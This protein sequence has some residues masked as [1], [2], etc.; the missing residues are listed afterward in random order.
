MSPGEF[1]PRS[2]NFN[3]WLTNPPVVTSP[4]LQSCDFN[5]RGYEIANQ[6]QAKTKSEPPALLWIQNGGVPI[7]TNLFRGTVFFEAAVFSQN[8]DFHK[9]EDVFFKK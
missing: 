5:R 3:F 2:F 9:H 4:T 1:L 7:F 8:V 6:V